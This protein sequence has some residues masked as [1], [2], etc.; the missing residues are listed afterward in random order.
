MWIAIIALASAAALAMALALVTE[1]M[2]RRPQGR[3]DTMVA[4][5]L[6]LARGE[7]I[8]RSTDV[9]QLRR[10]MEKTARR[11]QGRLPRVANI[12]DVA[13]PAGDHAIP[14]RIYA[15]GDAG[16]R[17]VLLCF[18]GGGFVEG[19][20]AT[21]ESMCRHLAVATGRLV[22]SVDYRLAPEHPFPAAPEDAYAVLQWAS[23][24]APSVGGLA[25][26]IAVAGD[27]AG[28][29]LSAI[30]CLMTRDRGGPRISAQVLL[31][32]AADLT[33]FDTGSYRDFGEGY[34]L[35]RSA[36]EF[37]TSLYLPDPADRA[38]PYASPLLAPSLEGVPRA[39]VITA[40]F[41]VLRDE[42]KAYADRLA[43]AGVPVTYSCTPGVPHGYLSAPGFL[44]KRTREGFALIARFLEGR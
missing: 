27:S 21:H 29:T 4:M 12:R 25:S 7:K 22:I 15:R 6:W 20:I 1:A 19:S 5:A 10:E 34:L 35:D 38:K 2:R 17:P 13:V 37:F 28:A 41:D 14:V 42:G 16:P 30:L 43:A 8:E 26:D 36:V 44:K 23:R 11:F 9:E 18:H 31:Y 32:P 3:L 24:E 40:Q 33:H 39:L